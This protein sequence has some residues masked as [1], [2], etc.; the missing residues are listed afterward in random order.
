MQA[1]SF[2]NWLR[3]WLN[4]LTQNQ[5]NLANKLIEL[6]GIEQ[7][8]KTITK[9]LQEKGFMMISHKGIALIKHY[10]GFKPYPYLCPAGIPTIGYGATYYPNGRKVTL[11]DK[12]ITEEEASMMLK[13]MLAKYERAV[14]R[15]VR[16]NLTQG[17]FDALVS[18]TYNLGL[19]ALQKS[20]LL[21]LLNQGNY[22]KAA[23]EFKKWVYANGRKLSGL[24]NRRKDEANLFRGIK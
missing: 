11:K 6:Q 24:R 14:N 9:K 22:T 8:K 7:T 12:H 3:I 5:V 10:E 18:F 15:Y 23:N 13:H 19:G 16:V 4:G 1:I 2:F 17:Q 21:R 20:T